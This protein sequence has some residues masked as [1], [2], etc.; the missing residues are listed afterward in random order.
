MTDFLI[1]SC[2][3]YK[4]FKKR[5]KIITLKIHKK[6][7]IVS[8]IL[9]AAFLCLPFLFIDKASAASVEAENQILIARLED[10]SHTQRFFDFYKS[11]KKELKEITKCEV[12]KCFDD[13]RRE[14]V[15]KNYDKAA[16]IYVKIAVFD[17]R[18][19]DA[20]FAAGQ[21]YLWNKELKKA[22]DWFIKTLEVS[23]G[24]IDAKLALAKTYYFNNEKK[25]AAREYEALYNEHG[26]SNYVKLQYAQYL[27][28]NSKYKKAA[29]LY[30]QVMAAGT[31]TLEA[32]LG[33]AKVYA[34]QK[35]YGAATDI[36]KALI[37]DYKDKE[38]GFEIRV[39][40]ARVYMFGGHLRSSLKLYSELASQNKNDE[41]IKAGMK[42]LS[43]AYLTRGITAY[44]ENNYDKAAEYLNYTIAKFPAVREAYKYSGLIYMSRASYEAALK[45]FDKYLKYNKD[46]YKIFMAA[47][48][49]HERLDSKAFA[50]GYYLKAAE[51][52]KR[53]GLDD[54]RIK[55][56]I[57]AGR[58]G[59]TPEEEEKALIA[60]AALENQEDASAALR[61]K[62]YEDLMARAMRNSQSRD[63]D[64]A[65]NDYREALVLKPGSYDARLYIALNLSW[66][67]KYLHAI[68]EY[69][70]I[71]IDYPSD[72]DVLGGIARTY[73]WMGKFYKSL[74]YYQE[75]YMQKKKS[76]ETITG[77][78]NAL[79]IFSLD[80]QAAQKIE[81]ALAKDTGYPYANS[82]K[83]AI[84]EAHE[85]EIKPFRQTS[86]DS[87]LIN[88]NSA[89]GDIALDIDL[90]TRLKAS[91]RNYDIF[92]DNSPLKYKAETTNLKIQ[93]QVSPLIKVFGGFSVYGF[94]DPRGG[95]DYNTGYLFGAGYNKVKHL[96]L[97]LYFDRS[98][99]FENP[100]AFRNKISMCGPVFELK[101]SMGDDYEMLFGAGYHV[102]S[103]S[104]TKK[105]LSLNFNKIIK[106][107]DF[108]LIA[109]PLYKYSAFKEKRYSGYYS[110]V[111]HYGGGLEYY[112]SYMPPA[113]NYGLI[114]N[115]EYGRSKEFEKFWKNYH[116]YVFEGFYSIRRGL[117]LRASYLKTDSGMDSAAEDGIGYW[118]ERFNLNL[119]YKW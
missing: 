17:P 56:L 14:S 47:A 28:W 16:A 119:S 45:R 73:F 23:P 63:Y 35:K 3:N 52:M 69:K 53:S 114:I 29:A 44:N 12:E 31:D 75:A 89:G 102:F 67:K 88:A 101:R 54:G 39:E 115:E 83:S 1:K 59:K 108:K 7:A 49:C 4:E 68:E 109:G 87:D 85:P 97:S 70:K 64:A 107:G 34:W 105:N 18:N 30:G 37:Q 62:Q 81:E 79:H 61:A 94:S 13:A 57:A 77:Y 42:E 58:N 27:A 20:M 46:D 26:G 48:Q 51:A 111:R 78:A 113:K 8:F 36:L 103:D 95:H 50:E 90:N 32:G 91:Y 38:E 72:S 21:N 65:I 92:M 19:S 86:K 100:A 117:E 9:M 15:L 41:R 22:R 43:M 99:I 5:K 60:L 25:A 118:Y 104:N 11:V 93:T 24:Y 112:L 84:K 6:N 80:R 33:L 71:L 96:N 76:L 98:I 116:K 10:I 2:L 55:E 74:N 106:K 40:L 110:P 82:L 66:Q